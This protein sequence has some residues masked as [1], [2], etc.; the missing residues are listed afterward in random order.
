M[1]ETDVSLDSDLLVVQ[2]AARVITRAADPQPAIYA[3][4]RILSQL[5]GL[6]RGRVLLPCAQ[7]EDVL[8]VEYAYGLTRQEIERGS[9]AIGEGVTGKG[10]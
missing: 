8:K 3:I 6:N 9:Y 10:L 5:L 4:L 7:S 2:E 1:S